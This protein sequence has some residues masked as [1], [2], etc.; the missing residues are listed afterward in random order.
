[1]MTF[2]IHSGGS[3]TTVPDGAGHRYQRTTP[4]TWCGQVRGGPRIYIYIYIQ[5]DSPGKH[6]L[7]SLD[8]L[9]TGHWIIKPPRPSSYS[10][11]P[12]QH[13]LSKC[14]RTQIRHNGRPSGEKDVPHG[15]QGQRAW[16]A[17][18]L[19]QVRARPA[20]IHHGFG[21]NRLLVVWFRRMYQLTP[22]SQ[23]YQ[24]RC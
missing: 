6:L 4:S 20:E 22:S 10:C 7:S 9:S 1:M 2:R 15:T 13:C 3:S 17:Y 23:T 5:T 11:P 8:F 12:I 14:S 21:N 19:E 18:L 16:R 24:Q